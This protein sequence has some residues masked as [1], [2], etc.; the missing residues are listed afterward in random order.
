MFVSPVCVSWPLKVGTYE[1]RLL[2]DDGYRL[3]SISNSFKVVKA[4]A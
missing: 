2:M 1:I 4:A 3:L